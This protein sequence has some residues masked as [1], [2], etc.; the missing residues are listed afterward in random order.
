MLDQERKILFK[1]H[2]L[3]YQH[4]QEPFFFPD[5]PVMPYSLKR[6]QVFFNTISLIRVLRL[7]LSVYN[8]AFWIPLKPKQKILLFKKIIKETQTVGSFNYINSFF[9]KINNN[10]DNPL[11][12]LQSQDT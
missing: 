5:Q 9:N 6:I 12:G 1:K 11:R 10:V 2:F 3:M 8:K 7:I 4:R